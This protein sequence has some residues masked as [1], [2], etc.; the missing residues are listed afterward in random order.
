[1]PPMQVLADDEGERVALLLRPE[2]PIVRRQSDRI[3]SALPIAAVEDLAVEQHDLV[4]QSAVGFQ[5]GAEF[6]EVLP[7]DKRE[8]VRERMERMGLVHARAFSMGAYS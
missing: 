8:E 1:M 5:P 4:V 6:V 2:G 3:A 7:F